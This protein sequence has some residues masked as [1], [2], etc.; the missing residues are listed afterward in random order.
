MS[1]H[2]FNEVLA[3]WMTCSELHSKQNHITATGFETG[4]LFE[5]V[6]GDACN[7]REWEETVKLPS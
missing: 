7:K 3:H 6:G 2:K 4:S 5:D 1:C